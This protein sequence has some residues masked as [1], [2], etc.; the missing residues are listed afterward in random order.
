MFLNIQLAFA[1][2]TDFRLTNHSKLLDSMPSLNFNPLEF[3]ENDEVS[4]QIFNRTGNS[5]REKEDIVANFNDLGQLADHRDDSKN[6]LKRSKRSPDLNG[7]DD[8]FISPNQKKVEELEKQIDA[9][10]IQLR[11][12]EQSHSE[13]ETELKNKIRLLQEEVKRLKESLANNNS[14]FVQQIND[15]TQRVQILDVQVKGFM[16]HLLPDYCVEDIEHRRFAAAEEKLK[17]IRR[18]NESLIP[19]IVRRAFNGRKEN[20]K[21]LDDFAESVNDSNLQSVIYKKFIKE[22]ITNLN[23]V[24]SV[25]T[26]W[27]VGYLCSLVSSIRQYKF[28]QSQLSFELREEL[29]G[30]MKRRLIEDFG[31]DCSVLCGCDLN[32]CAL[33]WTYTRSRELVNRGAYDPANVSNV[34]YRTANAYRCSS[35]IQIS[36]E[37]SRH[38]Q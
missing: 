33:Y 9:L 17:V 11:N 31:T 38:T 6:S 20:V 10:I 3:E 4:A 34:S 30:A 25:D 26:D 7:S 24:T 5:D 27:R 15:L 22:L 21:L 19:L 13:S 2:T 29:L 1:R 28:K 23:F 37:I 36:V 35:E 32:L 16:E 8:P 12:M 14:S 18:F